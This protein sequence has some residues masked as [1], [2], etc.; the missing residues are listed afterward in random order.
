MK[1]EGVPFTT[2]DWSAVAPVAH[3][4]ERGVA[5]SRTIEIGN[6][7]VRKVEYSAGYLADHWCA[8]GHVLLV[9]DGELIYELRAEASRDLAV[10]ADGRHAAFVAKS[11]EGEIVVIDQNEGKKYIAVRSPPKFV[12]TRQVVYLA[13]ERDGFLSVRERIEEPL[14]RTF[15]VVAEP[16]ETK[17]GFL[18]D[19]QS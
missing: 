9:L 6:L 8:R 4:G 13:Q 3:P 15:V 11:V 12:G 1:I 17:R 7:R 19:E 18:E 5:T 10:S 14:G 16:Q 2:M